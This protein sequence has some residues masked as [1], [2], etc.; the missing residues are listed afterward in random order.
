MF[1]FKTSLSFRAS[2]ASCKFFIITGSGVLVLMLN[3][4]LL[5]FD[6]D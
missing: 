5:A 6:N 4:V 2:L 3:L 1:M